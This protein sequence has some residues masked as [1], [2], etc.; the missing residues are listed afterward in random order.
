MSLLICSSHVLLCLPQLLLPF[1][2]IHSILFTGA[3]FVFLCTCLNHLNLFSRILAE[4]GATLNFSLNSW[5]LIVSIIVLAHMHLSIR[6]YVTFILYSK[7]LFTG[8]YS[9]P[10][11]NA[12]LIA[13]RK[14]L[15]FNLLGNFLSHSTPVAARHLSRPACIRL[16]TSPSIS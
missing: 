1:T 8:P 16:V 10:Y 3:S 4:R 2:M 12:G 14:N 6:I 9:V 13:T 15:L 7:T 11:N 5:F